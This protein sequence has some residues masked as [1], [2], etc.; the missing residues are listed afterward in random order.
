M[1]GEY[2]EGRVYWAGASGYWRVDN[3]QPMDRL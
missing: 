3:L 1:R 2:Q